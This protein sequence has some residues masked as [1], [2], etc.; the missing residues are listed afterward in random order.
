MPRSMEASRGTE[1]RVIRLADEPEAVEGDTVELLGRLEAQAEEMGRLRAK[2]ASLE[3]VA[4][5]E[6]DSRQAMAD[7][8]RSERRAAEAVHERATRAEALN[9]SQ[10]EEIERLTQ[11]LALVERQSEAM[12]EHLEIASQ[13]VTL[14]PPSLWERILR[15]PPAA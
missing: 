8:L 9:G 5:T 11:A 10:A 1:P 6:R 15:R 7:K 14:K 12:L 13:P 3:R 2:V 4:R